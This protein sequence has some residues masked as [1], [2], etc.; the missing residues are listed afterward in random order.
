MTYSNQA[1]AEGQHNH[2]TR[3][4]INKTGRNIANKL[5]QLG[6]DTYYRWGGVKREELGHGVNPMYIEISETETKPLNT[7]EI[8]DLIENTELE[9][10][11]PPYTTTTTN[12]K[13][14]N[15]KKNSVIISPIANS[16]HTQE[17]INESRVSHL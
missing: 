13:D 8:N 5:D 6:Y 16:V 7:D 4:E 12:G 2:S 3:V 1:T 10:I 9:L 17:Q 15:S 14:D 11:K